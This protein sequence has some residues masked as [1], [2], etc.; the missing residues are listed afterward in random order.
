MT[1]LETDVIDD[2]CSLLGIQEPQFSSPSLAMA[3]LGKSSSHHLYKNQMPTGAGVS[4]G[5]KL[6]QVFCDG[7]SSWPHKTWKW[8]P[9]PECC[10][11]CNMPEPRL[12]V[13]PDLE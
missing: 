6:Q 8:H 10:Q 5:A 3:Y 13:N 1:F 9:N 7:H 2:R 12:Q 4:V 11:Q